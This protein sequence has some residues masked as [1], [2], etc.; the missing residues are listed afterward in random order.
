MAAV[1][2][3]GDDGILPMPPMTMT[4]IL[5]LIALAPALPRTTIGRRG[6]ERAVTRLIYRRHSRRCWCY[7]CLHSRDDGAEEDGG[8]DRQGSNANIHGQEEVGHHD[9]IGAEMTRGQPVQR[10]NQPAC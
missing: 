9:P 1:D 5:A 8:G 4:A 3:G 7:L 6:G 10:D 2:G